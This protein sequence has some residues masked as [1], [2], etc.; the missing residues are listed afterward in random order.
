M[1]LSCKVLAAQESRRGRPHVFAAARVSPWIAGTDSAAQRRREADGRIRLRQDALPCEG[2][3]AEELAE[4]VPLCVSGMDSF[5]AP[6]AALADIALILSST[7][8]AAGVNEIFQS[9]TL[10]HTHTHKHGARRDLLVH[11]KS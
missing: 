7:S 10:G 11:S 5:S 2:N 9:A 8:C 1:A 6:S 4:A 3:R